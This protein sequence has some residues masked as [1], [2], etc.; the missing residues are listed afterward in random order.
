[1]GKTGKKTGKVKSILWPKE[2]IK[3]KTFAIVAMTDEENEKEFICKGTFDGLAKG[4][5]Y[6]LTGE[7]EQ[8]KKGTIFNAIT[9][10][11]TVPKEKAAILGY[12]CS[13]EG[14][15]AATAHRIYNAF[16]NDSI[17][18]L[19][20]NPEELK[21]HLPESRAEKAITAFTAYRGAKEAIKFLQPYGVTEALAVR[22]Y[23]KYAGNTMELLKTA[24]YEISEIPFKVIEEIAEKEGV[25]NAESRTKRIII[26]SV[27]D[28]MRN[29]HTCMPINNLIPQLAKFQCAKTDISEALKTLI[30]EKR[31]VF[32]ANP[33]TGVKN[34][35]LPI[36]AEAEFVI[37]REIQRLLSYTQEGFG[38]IDVDDEIRLF[39]LAQAELGRGFRLN[40]GQRNACKVGLQNNFCII[41]GGPG[42]GKTTIINV[43][44]SVYE[45]YFPTR[46]IL[47]CAPTGRASKRMTESTG[48]KAY[49]L[50]SVL[51][52]KPEEDAQEGESTCSIKL[53]YDFIVVD[54]ISMLDI[55][56]ARDFLRAIP[57]TCQVIL[58]G[59]PDQLPSVGPGAVLGDMLASGVVPVA[60]L[61]ETK[62]QS[63]DSKIALNARLM[64]AARDTFDYD[65]T[66]K[67]IES[68]DFE[69]AAQK[70]EDL[71]LE[72]VA[73]DG[74]DN[75]TILSPMRTAKTATGVEAIND[76]LHDKVNPP[77]DGKNEVKVWGRI[78]R[79][80]DKVMQTCN[81]KE[82]ANG[83]VGYITKIS[84]DVFVLDFEGNT[85]EYEKEDMKN[86]I[87]AYA[88]TV[89]KSQGSEYK[90]VLFN[91]MEQHGPMLKRNL[92]YTAITRA[93]K[94][95]FIIGSKKAMNIAVNNGQNDK[96]KRITT[97]ESRLRLLLGK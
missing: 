57:T 47:M 83:D 89:H 42:T 88:T 50:H 61:T 32:Q 20:R 86:I 34:L 49:T 25:K 52:L 82:I 60:K 84:G 64:Q 78:F 65:E 48:V 13:F 53:D 70:I 91:I 45:K 29:G 1:M 43:I 51:G 66:F 7:F 16:G 69:D 3:G 90:T 62:R 2:A 85:V 38:S 72:R 33:E 12:L 74:V 39:E 17:G 18:I 10:E 26:E 37:S 21:K 24:P 76:R 11:V 41:T 4:V 15:G 30:D 54:E 87:L 31:I 44:K 5:S 46:R 59:D 8:S 92:A 77:M 22:I 19:E 79:E 96:D 73:I 28:F 94:N 75:V 55:Y 58:I 40:P 56:I 6:A 80:G 63:G 97:L 68:E 27:R 71:F 36:V 14:I 95:C 67:F 81:T 9:A 23:K 93:K 35:S